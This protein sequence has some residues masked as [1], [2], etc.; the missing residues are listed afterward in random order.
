MADQT[1]DVEDLLEYLLKKSGD[2]RQ[3]AMIVSESFRAWFKAEKANAWKSS[4]SKSQG[5][6]TYLRHYAAKSL[7][8]KIQKASKSDSIE[9]AHAS[10]TIGEMADFIRA[11]R[12]PP[13]E[14]FARRE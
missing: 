6:D 12:M 1:I 9:D 3:L 4:Q 11:V 13:A 7:Y 2:I 10:V 14:F 5:Q 8:E